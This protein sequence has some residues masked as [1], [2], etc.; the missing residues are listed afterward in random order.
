MD[1]D[2][3]EAGRHAE[4]DAKE[5]EE[6]LPRVEGEPDHNEGDPAHARTRQ[7]QRGY[8]G[9]EEAERGEKWR[10]D[11]VEGHPRRH[12]R[13]PPHHRHCEREE[14]VAGRHAA[15]PYH[16]GAH[17]G[18]DSARRLD[19][20]KSFTR[21]DRRRLLMAQPSLKIDHILYLLTMDR[22]RRI[23]RDAAVLVENGRISRVG[24]AAELASVRADRVIDGRAMVVTPGFFNGHM[25]ISYGHPVRGI[26][27]D[28]QASP[29]E[30]LK[31][32]T[33]CFLDPGS[34]KFPDACLQAY[35]D[36]GI[37]AILG[38]CV[39]DQES[40]WALPRY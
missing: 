16:R 10:R 23:V 4:S 25:H 2:G 14:H 6:E 22:E 18:Q 34:T 20:G 12:E 3:S 11:D 39:T 17:D 19:S 21:D 1:D 36:A 27:P 30:L 31:S 26:F 7:P 5:L 32:G 38:E 33:T 15:R 35:Q 29:L 13:E 24:K 9:H 8:G 40:P 28:E 37:R